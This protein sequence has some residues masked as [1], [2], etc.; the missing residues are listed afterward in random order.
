MSEFQ[1]PT[2]NIFFP[3]QKEPTYDPHDEDTMKIFRAYWKK[4]KDRCINGFYIA[5]NQVFISGRLYFHVVYWKIAAYIEKVIGGKEKKVREIIT[6]MLRDVDWDVINE[7]IET[8][9]ELGQFYSLVG[10]R[11]WGKSIIGGSIAGHLYTFYDKS[12]ALITSSAYNYIKLA[13]DKIEDGLLNLH[14][15]FKKQRLTSD[16]KKEIVA[17]WKDNRTQLADPSSSFSSIKVRNYE[18]GNKSMAAVGTRPGFHLIDEIGTLP[19]LLGCIKDSEGAWWSGGG[20]KP[21]CFSMFTGTGGDMD[22]GKEAGELFFNPEAYNCLSFDNPEIPGAR[23][24]RFVSALRAKFKYKEPWT[25]YDYLTKK[26]GKTLEPHKD[27][28]IQ[29][30]VSNEERA[31]EEWWKPEYARALKSGNSKTVLKFKAFWPLKASDS[32]LVLTKNDYNIE[33][34]QKQQQILRSHGVTGSCVELYHNGEI[35]THKFSPK[36][37]ITEFPVKTQSKDAPIQVWEFPIDSTPPFGLYVAGVD[38][39]RQGK[40]EYSDSLGVVYIFKRMH[41]IYS[42]KYQ[43]ML[44]AAYAA[45]P[46]NPEKWNEQARMLIKWY[47]ART[48]CENDDMTFINYMISKG[49]GH[50]LEDQPQW[51]KLYVKNSTVERDKG[52]HRSSEKIRDMLR[53]LSKKYLDDPISVERDE[54]GSVIKEILGVT[55]IPD[56]M[57]LDEIIHFNEDEGNYDR[58]VAFS[59]AI[60]LAHHLDP[61]IGKV[62]GDGDPRIQSLF[63]KHPIKGKTLFKANTNIFSIKKRKLFSR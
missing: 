45:R 6:P 17:G 62:G 41:D 56:P 25:L 12:E 53:S 43:D 22:V 16:W 19:N 30:L 60:A 35:I 63:N 31:L 8:C 57:L 32:F 9:F 7:D 51:L 54:E 44:V 49:D 55:R 27:L 48:L 58:E 42:E 37:P 5:D 2:K 13:T 1:L 20:D 26:L 29:I 40:A 4:E 52:I 28:E 36:L 33:A 10:S 38:N 34:A 3:K 23:M 21:S 24:G 61:I 50:Y 18:G 46:E 39:Y 47:N 59:L 15:I 11:D 14:P